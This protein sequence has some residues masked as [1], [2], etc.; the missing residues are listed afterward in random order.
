MGAT[1]QYNIHGKQYLAP[2]SWSAVDPAPRTERMLIDQHHTP[3]AWEADQ[4]MKGIERTAGISP[5]PLWNSITIASS[6]RRTSLGSACWLRWRMRGLGASRHS[7]KHQYACIIV[8]CAAGIT[9]GPVSNAEQNGANTTTQRAV[10]S[11]HATDI[12][13]RQPAQWMPWLSASSVYES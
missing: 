11:I 6:P 5:E 12:A 2:A 3:A 7:N 1:L 13:Q 10:Q 8:S 9:W 4:P